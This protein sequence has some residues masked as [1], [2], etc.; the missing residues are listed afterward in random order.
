MS[1]KLITWNIWFNESNR[2]ARTIN[3]M[4]EIMLLNPDFVAFQEVTIE[5]SRIIDRLKK[6]YHLIGYP[7]RQTYDTLILSRYA[8]LEWSRYE[9]PNT[10]MGRNLLLGDFKVN[11]VIQQIGTFHLESVFPRNDIKQNQL[12]YISEITTENCILMGDTNFTVNKIPL[13]EPL[14]D[15]FEKIDSPQAYQYTYSGK[16]NKN[17]R[18][19]KMNS[20]LDRIYLKNPSNKISQFILLGTEPKIYDEETDRYVQLSD[21]YGIQATII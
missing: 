3:I 9:L 17:I 7:L 2:T 4:N 5:T 1:I 6:D 14:I 19:K 12:S 11:G 21:H 10:K 8:S 13:P 20:R 18:N 15:I 16:T